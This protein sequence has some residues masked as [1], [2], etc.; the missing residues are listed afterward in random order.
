M[1][2]S[3]KMRRCAG[4]IA[5]Y[6][7]NNLLKKVHD[8]RSNQGRRHKSA[9]PLLR[10]VCVGLSAKCKGLAQ[11][12]ELTQQMPQQVRKLIGIKSRLADTTMR[13]FL[14]AL[15]SYDICK[16]IYTVGYD[17]FRRKAIV[18]TKQFPW[19]VMSLD[20]KYPTVS[21]IGDG[22]HGASN[23][24]QVHH[25]NET[26]IA[27]H[28]V[29][30]VITAVLISAIGRPLLGASPVAG[31][32]NEVSHF[33]QAFGELAQYYRRY[34]RLVLY[35]AGA[36]SITNAATVV[37]AGKHYLFQ[38]ADPKWV[39]YKTVE[40]LLNNKIPVAIDEQIKSNKRLVRQL[41][42]CPV[43]KTNT[44]KVNQKICD[45]VMWP[46]IKT[47]FKVVSLVYENDKLISTKTR[48]FVSSMSADELKADKWLELIVARWGVET[49]HQ[50]LDV[51]FEEDKHPW[52]TKNANGA[53]VVMLLR[54]L[55]YTLLTL[56]KS[57]TL[58]SEESREMT[59]RQLMQQIRDTLLWA[60]ENIFD[61]LRPRVFA[62]P[63]ALY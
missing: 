12:E 19:G 43:V 17:A 61:G 40:L 59:W 2:T 13:D 62:V 5:R 52:I 38:I 36:A 57:V 33:K 16:L 48:F 37:K 44:P 63:P 55:V 24:L 60:K 22:K 18:S 15:N 51:S 53:L 11:L 30:R 10:S 39:M 50:I 23:Y 8:P 47:I 29:I 31:S 54:R 49:V 28:G 46:H 27:T 56:Y 41:Y 42:M 7:S 1:L 4:F 20:G 32:T 26:G 9:I 25:D 34:F 3:R 58:R 45:S 14:C 21:D 6:F 35:D